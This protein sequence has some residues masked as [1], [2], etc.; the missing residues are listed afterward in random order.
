MSLHHS[1]GKDKNRRLNLTGSVNCQVDECIAAWFASLPKGQGRVRVYQGNR[2][3]W[4]ELLTL[5]LSPLAKGRGE[6]C[7]TRCA[8]HC[9]GFSKTRNDMISIIFLYLQGLIR[10]PD[11]A[12]FTAKTDIGE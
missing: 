4:V 1:C 12:G 11:L 9:F 2:Q 8:L 6:K 3:L 10:F 5:V 7:H